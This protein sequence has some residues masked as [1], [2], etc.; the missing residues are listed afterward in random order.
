MKR[1]LSFIAALLGA[2]LGFVVLIVLLARATWSLSGAGSAATDQLDGIAVPERHPA[3]PVRVHSVAEWPAEKGR[4]FHE[5]PMLA[6]RVKAGKLPPVAERLPEDPLVVVPPDQNGPYGG[7]WSRFAT[8]PGDIGV[9]EARLSYDGFVRWGPMGRKVLPNLASRWTIEDGGCTYTFWLRR[10]VRWS[11]GH[12]FTA[13]DI[14]FWYNDVILNK[15]LTPIVSRD[16]RRGGEVVKLDKLDAHTIRFRFKEPHGLFLKQLAAG[17]GYIP[18]RYPAHYLKQFHAAYR[19][20]EELEAMARE[21][22]F[23]FWYQVFGDRCDWRNTEMPRLWPW[24]VKEPPPAQPAVFERNPFYWKVDPDGNQLPYIDQMTFQIFDIETINLKA[25]NGEMGMQSRHLAFNNYPLFME[26]RSKGGYRV[27]HW[28]SSGGG[29]NI[30]AINLNRDAAAARLAERDILDWPALCSK[31][32]AGGKADA[33]SPARRIWQLLP[34]E[35][36]ALARSAAG[37]TE[38]ERKQR[39]DLLAALNAVVRDRSFH[40]AAHFAGLELSREA[41]ELLA[42]PRAELWPEHVQR[43]NR[44]LFEA[45]FPDAIAPSRPPVL[46]RIVADRRF[47]IAL[48]H[49]TNRDELNEIGYFGIGRPRQVCPPPASPYYVPEY[50]SAYIQYDPAKA[51]RLLDEMGLDRRNRDGI[52]LRPDGEPLTLQI[53]VPSVFVDFR[54]FELVASHWTAVGVKTDVKLEARQLFYTRKA[55]LMHDVGVWGSA[56]EMNPILDPR[57][58]LPYSPESIHAINYSRWY[59]SEGKQGQEPPPDIRRC[60]DLYRQIQMT[61]DD[62]QHVRLFKEIIELNRKNLWVIGT[63]GQV[64]AMF[65]VKD[66]FRNVPDVAIAGW[67]FRTPGNTAPE[68]YAIDER[69]KPQGGRTRP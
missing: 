20:K 19:P 2:I 63:V 69:Q 46:K 41:S 33:P 60:I 30:L 68:C 7:T 21:K 50:E 67:V 14:L 23:H 5:A 28:I 17:M 55:A 47:R 65:L 62:A 18:I 42:Q 52:R 32:A 56:D 54:I 4:S 16:L 9:Y 61:P 59:T 53:E 36:R 35:A 22:G 39:T 64:P 29:E 1:Y 38:L 26:G 57:W 37:G 58:F 10:G 45:A 6:E 12:P 48:S 3:G 51:N 34:E 49:A 25:I 66:T 13:D 11:D 24:V 40:D 15:E 8:G 31:L 27:L 44:L 43:L